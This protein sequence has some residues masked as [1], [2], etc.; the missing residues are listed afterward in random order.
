MET[1]VLASLQVFVQLSRG[2]ALRDRLRTCKPVKAGVAAMKSA[3][4]TGLHQTGGRN[5]ARAHVHAC[6]R[7]CVFL[8]H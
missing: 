7:A 4:F 8:Q 6:V 5:R 1:P 3:F 2:S